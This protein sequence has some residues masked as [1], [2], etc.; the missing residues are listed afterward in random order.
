MKL[1]IFLEMVGWQTQ[2]FDITAEY[3]IVD[4]TRCDNGHLKWKEFQWS[5]DQGCANGKVEGKWFCVLHT[6]VNLLTEKRI[7]YTKDIK[8]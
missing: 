3:P 6:T 8:S 2:S 1:A 4:V 7:K 5:K